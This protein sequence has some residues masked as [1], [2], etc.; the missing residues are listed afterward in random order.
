MVSLDFLNSIFQLIHRI[1]LHQ[2][3]KKNK[4]SIEIVRIDFLLLHPMV[5]V[6]HC[7]VFRIGIELGMPNEDLMA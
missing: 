3:R 6:K 2:T 1:S 7:I 5:L 4:S